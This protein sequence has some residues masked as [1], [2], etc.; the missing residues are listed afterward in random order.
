MLKRFGPAIAGLVAVVVLAIG[1]PSATGHPEECST[2]AAWSSSDGGYSPY[3]SWQGAE[4]SICASESVTSRYDDSDARL[5]R[6]GQSGTA[7]L[8]L[9]ASRAKH[10]TFNTEAAFNSDLAF[11]DGYA[12]QGNYEGVTIYDVRDPSNP[13]VV[14]Q[15]KCPG[16]Q[17]DVTINDGILITSTDSRRTNNSCSSSSVP[18]PTATNPDPP[19]VWE[20]LKVWNVEDPTDPPEKP[21]ATVATDCGSH[22][23]TVLPQASRL[24]VYVQSYDIGAGRT[25][26][27]TGTDPL[28]AHDKISVVEVPKATP[29][30]ASV[31][32]EPVLFPD[33]GNRGDDA[34]TRRTNGTTGC[35][36]ITVYQKIGLAAGACTGEGAI[37]DIKDPV[38]PKVIASIEDENFAFWHSATISQDGKKVLFTDELGGGGQPTCNSTIG[39]KRG[40]DAIYDIT[41]PA[42]PK[43]MSYF[44]IPREQTNQENCVAHNGNAI[45]VPGRDILIQSWYQGGASI[46]DWTNGSNVKELAW[47]DRGPID[48]SRLVLGGFWSTYYYNGHI[49]GS[50]IQRGFDVF[51]ATG[52]EFSQADRTKVRTLNA[53]TQF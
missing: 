43:F 47:F 48:S 18:S 25:N 12:Y 34:G 7:G 35:H 45:P 13:T 40:A 50:E 36:D 20:G 51:K 53:Q 16:S 28:K 1:V 15:I 37:I 41:D 27:D 31:I 38:N 17:N 21:V 4:E 19:G 26:C 9:I 5:T 44:K 2:A 30:A 24:L 49:Y 8:K 32:N 10:G 39:P 46:I 23:H 11:E 42:N 33:G 6:E 52:S 14:G 29:G 3:L 22:T